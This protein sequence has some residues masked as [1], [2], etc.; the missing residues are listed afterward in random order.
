M[1]RQLIVTPELVIPG[2][3]LALSYARSA[4]PGG[5]NVNKVS[6]KAV[7]RWQVAATPSLPAA[8]RQRFVAKYGN[9]INAAGELVIAADEHREQSRNITACYER[10]RQ[11][12][13]AVLKPPRKRVKTRPSRAAVE[14]RVE[15]K[16]RRSETKERR[17]FRPES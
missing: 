13:V 8:V 3:E 5:Q 6:S 9:R 7:L 1:P 2:S 4:G 15:A 17:R 16:N 11:M 14:R 10:L 12:I